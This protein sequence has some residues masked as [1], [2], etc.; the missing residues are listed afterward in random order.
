M[1]KA[2]VIWTIDDFFAYGMIVSCVTKGYVECP[3]CGPNTMTRRPKTMHK[4]VFCMC[5]CTFLEP[6]HYL[7]DDDVHFESME[8]HLALPPESLES[9]LLLGE[10]NVRDSFKN[11]EEGALKENDNVR[12]YDIKR[13]SSLFKL[14][15][16][17]V[18]CYYTVPTS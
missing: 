10:L 13:A 2:M 6:D 7:C 15:Y 16:W 9:K 11:R 14:P 5:V 17:K 18:S 3:V 1:L 4:N 8:R 12:K